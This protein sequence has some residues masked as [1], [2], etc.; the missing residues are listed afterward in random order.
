MSLEFG[1]VGSLKLLFG[2]GRNL[3]LLFIDGSGNLERTH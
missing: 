2:G 3:E 1:S